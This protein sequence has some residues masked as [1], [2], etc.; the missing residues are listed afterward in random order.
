MADVGGVAECADAGV[1]E[2]GD[3]GAAVVVDEDYD[4]AL[5][6]FASGDEIAGAHCFQVRFVG[7]LVN[8]CYYHDLDLNCL[9]ANY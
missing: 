5:R 2:C 8:S 6:D 7:G 9:Y 1:A 3:A 4:Y